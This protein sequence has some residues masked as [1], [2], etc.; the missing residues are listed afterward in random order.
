MEGVAELDRRRE[1][2]AR[3]VPLRALVKEGEGEGVGVAREALL[4]CLVTRV[5][6]ARTVIFLP[7][8][9]LAHRVRILFGL[10]SLRV[11][12]L[13]GNMTQ[14]QRMHALESFT[15]GSADFLVATDL[16]GRGLDIRGVETVINYELPAEMATYVHRVGRTARAGD[17]GRAVSP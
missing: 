14:L 12:E 1:L 13:H 17:A 7:S 3:D 16:A 8:K 11:A 9:K 6:K 10:N 4:L 5:F 15:N 2:H